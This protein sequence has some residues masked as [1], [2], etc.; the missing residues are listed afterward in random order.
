[1]SM[2]SLNDECNRWSALILASHTIFNSNSDLSIEDQSGSS[3]TALLS[4]GGVPV[5]DHWLRCFKLAGITNIFVVSN[6]S[7]HPYIVEWALT[8]GILAGNI[9]KVD[10]N[11][12]KASE[13]VCENASEFFDQVAK[14]SDLHAALRQ[15]ILKLTDQNLVIV[16]GNTLFQS[17]FD[18]RN[19]LSDV[20]IDSGVGVYSNYCNAQVMNEQSART[21]NDTDILEF[22]TSESSKSDNIEISKTN[23]NFLALTAYR[24]ASISNI[25]EYCESSKKENQDHHKDLL[26]RLL[27]QT[28]EKGTNI[29]VRSVNNIFNITNITDYNL[30]D[31]Y[32]H[33]LLKKH[34]ETLPSTVTQHCPA[35]VGLMGNPSDGFGGKTLSFL[36][37]NF[38]A[39]VTITQN[40]KN[41]EDEEKRENGENGETEENREDGNK[42]RKVGNS[43]GSNNCRD[44]TLVPHPVFD[45]STFG[46]MSQLQLHTINKVSLVVPY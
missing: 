11:I 37:Q 39:Q 27:H 42:E 10:Q 15:G 25:L 18:L 19:L 21:G 22:E 20:P 40:K 33:F 26:S 9:L 16:R 43:R 36:I 38:S 14:D 29:S 24:G 44:V 13:N 5:L 1:M 35:R 32:F 4:L 3:P 17:D 8:R 2:S 31:K 7:Y 12:L 45:P 23:R 34:Q 46:G 28:V 6:T 41:D 30:T